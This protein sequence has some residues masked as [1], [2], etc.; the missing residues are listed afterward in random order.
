M[1]FPSPKSVMGAMRRV[2]PKSKAYRKDAYSAYESNQ[3]RIIALLEEL[4]EQ[5]KKRVNQ[6]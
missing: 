2:A 4:V 3:L 5:G 6:C 1:F